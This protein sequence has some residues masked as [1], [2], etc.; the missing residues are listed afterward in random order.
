MLYNISASTEN[1]VKNI[2]LLEQTYSHDTRPG[3]VA[4]ALG[5]SNAAT[6][7]MARK[8]TKRN[9]V[10]YK[11][12]KS[13]KLTSEGKKLALSVLR[14]HRL[15]ETFL[16]RTFD[17]SLHEIHR[18]AELLEHQTTDFLTEKIS[19]YLGD[20]DIDPHGDPI[21]NRDGKLYV[22]KGQVILTNAQAGYSYEISRLFS[23]NKEFF[24]FCSRNDINVGK[25]L[26]VE[27]QYV[28]NQM[29]E[30]SIHDTRLLLNVDFSNIIYVTPIG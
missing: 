7:D 25:V 14:K 6:T 8:L 28:E 3:S 10:E 13:L 22:Q 19:A 12:Y 1:F 11:K 24:D 2:Y 23:S 30:V 16:Y 26:K 20:P 9:L 21:P 29:T 17:F 15:W 18:E 27:N 4:R 5:I